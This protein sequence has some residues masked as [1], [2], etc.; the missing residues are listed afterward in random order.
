[1]SAMGPGKEL[2]SINRKAIETF[3]DDMGRLREEGSVR[4]GLWQ[5]SRQT[6][7]KS[8]SEA[9]W[10]P[11][12]PY[13]DSSVAEAWKIFEAGFLTLA[14]VPLATYFSPK[15]NQARELAAVAMINYVGKGGH[16]T[17]SGLVRKRYEHH[18]EQFGLGLEDF[19][20]GELGNT[21]A[22]LGNSTPCALWV[23][24]HIF[25]DNQVLA[26]VR[27]EVSALVVEDGTSSSIDLASIKVSC[28]VLLSTFQET[29]RYRATNSGPRV[30]LE[31]H[32]DT[33][34]WGNDA[35]KFDHMRFAQTPGPGQKRP[36]R[37]AFRAFG[38][39]HVLCPGR[40][41]ASTEIMAL[42]A[43][44]VLQFD[45]VPVAGQWIEP[46]CKNSPVQGS[47]PIP[48]EDI[49]VELRARDPSRKWSVTYS[50][51]DEAMAIVSEDIVAKE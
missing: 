47:F 1:M 51:S 50:G 42:A 41:F 46:T 23:L 9:V 36:N 29:M 25:S 14:V 20:R 19:A 48:D 40:H 4:V 30:V 34:A 37:V 10:G 39:G 33:L 24:Y 31:D 8:T 16:K 26:D 27:R 11:Q 2:D 12:N 6:M 15:L 7:V 38:G 28:P 32:T 18:V 45:V 21:F 22:V 43:F 49:N 17:A 5:W 44:L 13:R 35:D 3:A